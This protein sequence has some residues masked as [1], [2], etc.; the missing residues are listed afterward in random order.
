MSSKKIR[1]RR[2]GCPFLKKNYSQQPV[3]LD[4]K[5][6]PRKVCLDLSEGKSVCLPAALK[7][8]KYVISCLFNLYKNQGIKML[9]DSL[10]G[11]SDL[12]AFCFLWRGQVTLDRAKQAVFFML[13]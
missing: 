12:S 1:M 8:H 9:Y 7:L 2:V 5:K 10:C 11:D 3:R 6:N 13:S 4:E